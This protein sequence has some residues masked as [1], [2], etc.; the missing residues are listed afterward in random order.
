VDRRIFYE[1]TGMKFEDEDFDHNFGDDLPND[2]ELD[3]N[4]PFAKKVSVGL[5]FWKGFK[6]GVVE[7]MIGSSSSIN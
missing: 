3:P 7:P 6:P 1:I 4:R 2:K 5:A